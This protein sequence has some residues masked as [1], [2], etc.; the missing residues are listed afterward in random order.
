M[1]FWIIM[2]NFAAIRSAVLAKMTFEV[3]IL[4]NF[5]IFPNWNCH[6]RSGL[7]KARCDVFSM[8]VLQSYRSCIFVSVKPEARGSFGWNWQLRT[9]SQILMKSIPTKHCHLSSSSRSSL[10]MTRIASG[11]NACCYRHN[12]H[13]VIKICL[14]TSF[15]R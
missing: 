1:I 15:G 14:S 4:V 2:Q 5:R 8:Y 10:A 3:A 11:V 9:H 13:D 12:P 6:F 7:W